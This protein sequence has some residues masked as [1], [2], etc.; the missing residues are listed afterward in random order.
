[1]LPPH[2]LCFN[3]E[4]PNW[5]KNQFWIKNCILEELL[6]TAGIFQPN[7]GLGLADEILFQ[8]KMICIEDF[9]E[10]N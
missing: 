6:V 7:F 4:K 5:K 8:T 9:S 2:W 10:R 3:W 1:M